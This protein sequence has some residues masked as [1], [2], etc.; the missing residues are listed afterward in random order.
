MHLIVVIWFAIPYPQKGIFSAIKTLV[1]L[2]F[3]FF[4][5]FCVK[6]LENSYCFI[7]VLLYLL[8]SQVV[9]PRMFCQ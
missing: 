9:A 2:I 6:G 1:I 4:F 3:F 8:F 7:N 5:M